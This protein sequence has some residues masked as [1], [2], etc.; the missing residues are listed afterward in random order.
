MKIAICDDEAIWRQQL[1]EIV[2]QWANIH[3]LP[4]SVELFSGSEGFLFAFEQE[5]D[6]DLLLLDIEMDGKNGMELAQT[7]RQEGCDAAIIFTTGYEEYMPQ[8]F[9]V[10]A[11]Q[12]L[13][14]PVKEEKLIAC[15]DRIQE[16]VSVSEPKV[17]FTTAEPAKLSFIP[18]RIWYVEARGHGC[19]LNTEN[20]SYELKESI[21]E[22]E[23]VLRETGCIVKCHRSYL[24]NLRF[25]SEIR[26]EEIILDDGRRIPVS[27]STYR[28]LNEAFIRF[29]LTE[30]EGSSI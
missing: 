4:L 21:S 11:M 2:V 27:K 6:W 20:R 3:K 18:S 12:Y 30:K 9:E 1:K 16:R 26:R 19:I 28:K 23:A 7:L 5:K 25:I 22:T 8:G 17:I 14:K 15:L 10:G 24:V 13:I 29:Y